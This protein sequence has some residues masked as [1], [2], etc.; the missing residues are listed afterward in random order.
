LLT[1]NLKIKIYR[2]IILN[3]VLYWCGTWSL[4]L[5]EERRL[6]VFENRV[7]RRIFGPKR[8]EVMEKTTYEELSQLYSSPNIV[9][10]IKSS[11]MRWAGHVARMGEGR[12]VYRVLVGR[13]GGKRPLGR[14]RRR[15]EDNITMNLQ[16]VGCRDIDWIELA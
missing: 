1:K 9:R 4:T 12:G 6:R 11:R 16:E 3:V 14:P 7:L 8:N 2:T 15:R 10:V 13:S 5:T